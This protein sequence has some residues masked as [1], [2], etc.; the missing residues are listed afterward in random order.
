MNFARL[1]PLKK[2]QKVSEWV[3]EW[4]SEVAGTVQQILRADDQD[5][6]RERNEKLS[7]YLPTLSIII[8]SYKSQMDKQKAEFIQ[9]HPPP[10]KGVTA[11]RESLDDHLASN[12]RVMQM[13]ESLHE[14]VATRLSVA[15]TTLRTFSAEVKHGV[16][17]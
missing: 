8:A 11:W 3:E 13:V 16:H 15:Q 17:S 5:G 6:L 10:E 14:D 12:K 1:L 7:A 4:L 2:G 9:A